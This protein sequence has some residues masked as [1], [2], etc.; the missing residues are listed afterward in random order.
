[1]DRINKLLKE[2]KIDRKEAQR[3][4]EQAKRAKS[5]PKPINNNALS[6]NNGNA[7][8]VPK[9]TYGSGGQTLRVVSKDTF[10]VVTA[11]LV[12]TKAEMGIHVYTL[13]M[14][15]SATELK[16]D[17][18][19]AQQY[20][21][22]R[23]KSITLYWEPFS[24]LS[25]GTV[26]MALTRHEM[27]DVSID[28]I[29]TIP[30][31]CTSSLSRPCKISANL[32]TEVNDWHGVD[33]VV[34]NLNFYVASGVLGPLGIIS[35]SYDVEF[36]DPR[37]AGVAIY[38]PPTGNDTGSN[39][40]HRVVDDPVNPGYPVGFP[41]TYESRWQLAEANEIHI[42]EAKWNWFPPRYEPVEVTPDETLRRDS[43]IKTAKQWAVGRN[44]SDD[45]RTRGY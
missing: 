22:C 45:L 41:N 36:A 7:P 1:M 8:S 4:R 34:R 25:Q 18:F 24:V 10:K 35:V 6:R 13:Q 11:H 5:G 21:S 3:R 31:N 9:L 40:L 42:S 2:G 15:I 16:T 37:S 26:A 29:L 44:K 33:S 23:F 14:A 32:L 27:V 20:N 12:N 19:F 30:G 39:I 17:S 38:K 28:S 43:W